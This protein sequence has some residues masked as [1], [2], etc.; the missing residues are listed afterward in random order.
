MR[1]IV[2]FFLDVDIGIFCRDKADLKGV[3]INLFSDLDDPLADNLQ[4][5]NLVSIVPPAFIAGGI[6]R[7]G[8][9]VFAPGT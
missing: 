8:S 3:R 5:K 1:L 2:P 9:P 7:V 6:K 4:I